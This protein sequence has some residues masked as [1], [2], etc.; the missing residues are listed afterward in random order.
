M[1]RLLTFIL[2]GVLTI[3]WARADRGGYTLK[4]VTI[5]AV[6][7]ENSTWD[8]TETLEVDFSEPRHGIYKYIP[9]R[10]F[11]GF[12]NPDGSV[13]EKVY[14]NI[15]RGISVDG[16]DYEVEG[17]DTDAENTIIRIGSGDYCVEGK[18]VYNIYYQVQYLDD[19]F[20]GEDFLCHTIW[21]YG[22]NT[23]VEEMDFNIQ[24]DMPLPDEAANGLHLYSGPRGSTTNAAGVEM[25]YDKASHA[26]K[27]H[28]ANMQANSAITISAKLPEGFWEPE[29]KNMMLFYFFV[30][31][32]VLCAV[33]YVYN[34]F[35]HRRR[36]PIPVVSFYPP[37]GISSAE[38]GKIIDD[39]TDP[40]DLASLVP[41]LAHRGNI[42]IEEIPDSKGRGGKYADLKLT[43][44]LP[45]TPDAPKYQ[46]YFMQALFGNKNSV[47]LGQLGD[48]HAEMNVATSALDAIYTGKQQ[49]TD[50]GWATGFWFLMLISALGM[51]WTASIT[52]WF[53]SGLA[54]LACC[55]SLGA[56]FLIGMIRQ[57]TAPKRNIRSTGS[58]I[59]EAIGCA[60]IML[61][62][63]AIHLFVYDDFDVC[64]PAVYLHAGC[65]MLSLL[66]YLADR[67]VYDSEYRLKIMGEL[68]GLREFIK[69]AEMPRLK[70][71]VD[72]NPG[73]F[74]EVLPY[75]IVFGLSDKWA[76]LFKDI[77]L[78]NPDWYHPS[79]VG[80]AY[81]AS[82][83]LSHTIS[84]TVA[85]SIKSAV[86]E[87]SVDPTSSSSSG[88]YS[89]GG[90]SFSGGGGGG[91]GG[92]SW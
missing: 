21:G 40:E 52:D 62:G 3:S 72:E 68:L 51:Y 65:V 78:D 37:N 67:C 26:I 74:Y 8:V 17:D 57:I 18:Q 44:K 27:G 64:V 41:W 20:D 81:M 23:E 70:M 16:Y 83:L 33:V 13:E 85:E 5:N 6:V 50:F 91:G 14:K 92:G 86:A 76:D 7:H 28:V 36:D 47:I 59:L 2:L 19:R 30:F 38:V 87:A 49:L 84:T 12:T 35:S 58:K 9:S 75:A 56:A 63:L 66:S 15:I 4:H 32:T 39:S 61:V 73:Y 54:L 55:S 89:G 53:D 60:V 25:T 11:Y 88:G 48:R 71:L 42:I 10:F 29:S 77:E 82:S 22:W 80:S 24:F 31:V 34:L 43:K 79:T 1:K 90:S 69:N 45:L 46:V